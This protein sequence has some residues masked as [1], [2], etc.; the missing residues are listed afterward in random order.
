MVALPGESEGEQKRQN[1]KYKEHI[2]ELQHWCY[3]RNPVSFS[4]IWS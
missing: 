1:G 2:K 4:E 3:V